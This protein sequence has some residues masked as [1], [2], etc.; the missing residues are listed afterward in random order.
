MCVCVCAYVCM[1]SIRCFI[2]TTDPTDND[3]R[4]S[5]VSSNCS[6]DKTHRL[7]TSTEETTVTDLQVTNT[8]YYN[9][10]VSKHSNVY[11]T[12]MYTCTYV[13]L[14]TLVYY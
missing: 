13:L 10:R 2:I 9:E 6:V 12:Y 7:Q 3:C 1:C 8:K 4:V 14:C 11:G 5:A